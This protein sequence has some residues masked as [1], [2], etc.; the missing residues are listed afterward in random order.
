MIFIWS[1]AYLFAHCPNIFTSDTIGW[2]I[3][4][5]FCIMIDTR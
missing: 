3:I 2:V 4:L 1:I 5:A